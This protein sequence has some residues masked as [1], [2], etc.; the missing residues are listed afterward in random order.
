M[1]I[2]LCTYTFQQY[3]IYPFSCPGMLRSELNTLWSEVAEMAFMAESGIKLMLPMNRTSAYF[4]VP[5]IPARYPNPEIRTYLMVLDFF[6][7]DYE[8]FAL[9]SVIDGPAGINDKTLVIAHLLQTM[10]EFDRDT[11]SSGTNNFLS[12]AISRDHMD[13]VDAF[14]DLR[15]ERLP[16]VKSAVEVLSS[17]VLSCCLKRGSWLLKL[18]VDPCAR[19][20]AT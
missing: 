10:G 18:G 6:D 14:L 5:D 2:L 16:P 1:N 4:T 15:S 17:A 8:P 12:A 19:L 9:I 3:E 13:A 11:V 20:R 7:P